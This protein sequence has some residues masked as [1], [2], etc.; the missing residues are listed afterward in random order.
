M[1]NSI[2][3]ILTFVEAHREDIWKSF[4][5]YSANFYWD[6][7]DEFKRHQLNA[8]LLLTLQK[9]GQ[10]F[11][12]L[13]MPVSVIE[14]L[15]NEP[16]YSTYLIPKKKGGM[17][18]IQEPE[19]LL[20]K[21]QKRL[22]YFLQAY[23]LCI[24][25][26]EVHGFV[27]HPHYGE[28]YCNIVA[29]SAPHIKK[30]YVLNIDLKDFF[31]GITA[32][33]VKDMFLSGTFRYP[34]QLA[35]ALTLL[36]T[37]EGRLPQGA[38]TSPVISNFICLD[39]DNDLKTYAAKNA[40]TYTRYADDLSFSSNEVIH[41]DTVL[42][43]I[44]IINSHGF[45]INDKKLRIRSSNRKQSVTGLTVNEKVNVDRKLL[46]K[47][48]A[49]V[50]DLSVNGI[51]SAARKHFQLDKAPKEEHH[52]MFMK[53]LEGYINFIG[54]VRGTGDKHYMNFHSILKSEKYKMSFI[55]K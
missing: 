31:P 33:W 35:T 41:V 18:I 47:V 27:I 24:K 1:M 19:I 16:V 34:D 42:D 11:K 22:N 17:R 51:D 52:L 10:L 50:H 37:Y 53:R 13:E 55:I 46:K 43:I 15:I 49:M 2:T 45:R 44:S 38:P 20:K 14:K 29:N 39:L 4:F 25:P 36:T 9:P 3:E 5:R 21:V 32:R 40:L 30:K 6:K 48:R 28:P 8:L 54:Q 26:L 7:L 12:F 23:Y